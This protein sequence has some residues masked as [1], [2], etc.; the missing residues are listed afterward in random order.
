MAHKNHLA[1]FVLLVT[2]NNTSSSYSPDNNGFFSRLY[3]SLFGTEKP[4]SHAACPHCQNNGAHTPYG[5]HITNAYL[6]PGGNGTHGGGSDSPTSIGNLIGSLPASGPGNS[7]PSSGSGNVLSASGTM[8]EAALLALEKEK[9][10]QIELANAGKVQVEHERNRWFATLTKYIDERWTDQA[11]K[12]KD[13]FAVQAK[14]LMLEHHKK[15]SDLEKKRGENELE[16]ERIRQE[17]LPQLLRHDK[18]KTKLQHEH[19]M[20]KLTHI[21][22]GINSFTADKKRMKQT[23][24]ALSGLALGIFA[25]KRGTKVLANYASSILMKPTLVTETSRRSLNQMVRH[26]IATLTKKEKIP[27]GVYNPE[28]Q[29]QVDAYVQSIKTSKQES[30]PYRHALLYGPPGTGKT[31]LAKTVARDLNMHYAIVPGANVHQFSDTQAI[32]EI[33]KLFDWAERGKTVIF[34]DEVD[35]FAPMRT[36]S[37]SEKTRQVQ[38]TFYARTGTETDKYVLLGATNEPGLLDPAYISRADEKFEFSLPD[39]A[40]RQRLLVQFF[41]QYVSKKSSIPIDDKVHDMWSEVATKTE[42]FSGR[43]LS[44]LVRSI[45]PATLSLKEKIITPA[46]IDN[47]VQQKIKQ[48]ATLKNYQSK[49]E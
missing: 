5:Q 28:L 13:E 8:S 32:E 19:T 36:G 21:G 34:I 9:T 47:V 30:Q 14:Q 37:I 11:K 41:E 29:A 1:L 15:L 7:G 43:D 6:T 10:K 4:A 12:Q 45:P 35:A 16:K 27:Q 38:N 42:G 40:T 26:P 24:L 17:N 39:S 18:E 44:Q 20:Q 48:Q 25:S 23:T 22:Q 2:L 46:V 31:L 3:N 33:N 49:K